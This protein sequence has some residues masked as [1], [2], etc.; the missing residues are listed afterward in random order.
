MI[1]VKNVGSFVIQ[2]ALG[3]A[4]LLY[5]LRLSPGDSFLILNLLE[6]MKS[7]NHKL[8]K[9]RP[10]SGRKFEGK[11]TSSNEIALSNYNTKV[12]DEIRTGKIPH[13]QVH[14]AL[15]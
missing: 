14:Q 7:K 9:I 11:V 4:S 13:V 1:V 8:F 3:F 5:G 12:S 2:L 6:P 10:L 15:K